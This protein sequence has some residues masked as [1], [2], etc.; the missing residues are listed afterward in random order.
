MPSKGGLD[1]L[2]GIF[3]YEFPAIYK[4]RKKVGASSTVIINVTLVT[5]IRG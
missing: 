4:W 2:I 5:Q 3:G 1:R